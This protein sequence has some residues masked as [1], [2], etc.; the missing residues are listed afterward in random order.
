VRRLWRRGNDEAVGVDRVGACRG[1]IGRHRV[2]DQD[3]AH[4]ERDGTHG[5]TNEQAQADAA[6]TTQDQPTAREDTAGEQRQL[7]KDY[8]TIHHEQ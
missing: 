2:R 5:P 8:E 4:H 6:V 1:R 7:K 3:C